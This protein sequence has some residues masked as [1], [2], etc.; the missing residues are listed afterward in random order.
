M[1]RKRSVIPPTRLRILT[2]WEDAWA[3]PLRSALVELSR[4]VELR[5]VSNVLMELQSA[6]YYHILLTSAESFYA[7][8]KLG[9][10]A[11]HINLLILAPDA[12]PIYAKPQDLEVAPA[13]IALQRSLEITA[14]CDLLTILLTNLTDGQP[15]PNALPSSPTWLLFESPAIW[16]PKRKAKTAKKQPKMRPTATPFN[17]N[18]NFDQAHIGDNINTGDIGTLKTESRGASNWNVQGDVGYIR[19]DGQ[20]NVKQCRRCGTTNPISKRHCDECGG[21]F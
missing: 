3:K 4:R 17:M 14:F 15:L 1:N 10:L 16:P 2:D 19:H 7:W 18:F 12:P 13:V 5:V 20:Q 11:T 8:Q 21:R 6:D 9:K